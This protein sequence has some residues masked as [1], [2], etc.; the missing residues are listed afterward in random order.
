MR[1]I[2]I[3]TYS[4]SENKKQ[5]L[6]S[7]VEEIDAIDSEYRSFVIYCINKH[8]LSNG[9]TVSL[10]LY[11]SEYIPAT[12]VFYVTLIDDKSFQI[13]IPLYK[14][15]KVKNYGTFL[16]YREV[17]DENGDKYFESYYTGNAILDIED[18]Y[19]YYYIRNHRSIMLRYYGEV[20]TGYIN[21]IPGENDEN[22]SAKA[23]ICDKP[24]EF[25][26]GEVDVY[27]DWYL[28]IG[29]KFNDSTEIYDNTLY[30]SV[31]VGLEVKEKYDLCDEQA[32]LNN[33][34]KSILSNIIPETIDNEKHQ[35][36]PVIKNDTEFSYAN[37]I[38]FNFH[39][40]D[41]YDENKKLRED[42]KSTDEQF[43]NG[44]FKV[45]GSNLNSES[46]DYLRYNVAG[47][48]DSLGDELNHLGFTE[49]DIRYSKK[50]IKKTFIRLLFYSTPNILS[51]ELL[52]YST[53]FFDSNELFNKYLNIKG[54]G[55]NV[56]DTK[57]L[58]DSLRLSTKFRITNKY[59]NTKSSEGFYM[60]LF[61]TEIDQENRERTIYMKVEFNHAGYGKTVPMMLPT[62]DGGNKVIKSTDS[63]F[64]INFI[65]NENG[66]LSTHFDKY[67][68]SVMIPLTIKYDTKLKDYIYYFPFV[69]SN[70]EH[71]IELNLFEPRIK[72]FEGNGNS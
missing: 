66:L 47:Y 1:T 14:K 67:Q 52:Y 35:F 38:V 50:K 17:E 31:P 23:I 61:P 33:C 41:R 30:I 7:H 12:H 68:S 54:R 20:F 69:E 55:L 24:L 18:D 3:N 51:K 5:I 2:K 39:F 11:R 10:T 15:F 42:W 40:R 63:D 26:E 70:Q 44:M 19:I 36:S 21:Y 25:K 48:N 58:D 62:R 43:W 46:D 8:G 59:N 53:V 22:L 4:V 56:F 60:Y 57:R 37:E 28:T 16:E 72:G 32:N 64:P 29:D 27:L 13:D 49:D 45:D 34:M 65:K 9:D 71:K 6:Y